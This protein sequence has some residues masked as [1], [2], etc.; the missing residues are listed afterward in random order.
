M[1]GNGVVQLVDALHL[2]RLQAVGLEERVALRKNGDNPEAYQPET[3]VSLI[4][5]ICENRS[6]CSS[7]SWEM[8]SFLQSVLMSSMKHA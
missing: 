4:D 2:N 7:T 6:R 1:S 5:L 3:L 8:T